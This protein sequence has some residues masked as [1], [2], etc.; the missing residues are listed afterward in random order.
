LV[1]PNAPTL[2]TVSDALS[3]AD[4]LKIAGAFVRNIVTD[5]VGA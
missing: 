3:A 5:S 2:A 4:F 1:H